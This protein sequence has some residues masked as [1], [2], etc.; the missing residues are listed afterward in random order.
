[1]Y[2]F[3]K[4]KR[5]ARFANFA[6]RISA[7]HTRSGRLLSS[8]K[9][10]G[11]YKR[12]REL[13]AIVANGGNSIGESLSIGCFLTTTLSSPSLLLVF[14][15]RGTNSR[16]RKFFD[17]QRSNF[18][19]RRGNS[20]RGVRKSRKQRFIIITYI[21]LIYFILHLYYYN[22]YIVTYYIISIVIVLL[23]SLYR[24]M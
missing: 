7:A 11:S 19:T 14:Q 8:S 13:S 18:Y 3:D 4:F 24:H 20:V 9:E 22:L 21:L 1:M 16:P 12:A 23:N 5:D 6:K 10:N 17:V 2:N 15:T